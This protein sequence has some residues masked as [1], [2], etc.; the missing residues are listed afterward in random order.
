MTEQSD[1]RSEFLREFDRLG[2]VESE[3]SVNSE[4]TGDSMT[5]MAIENVAR[6]TDK[7]GARG[8]ASGAGRYSKL[9]R[10]LTAM[11]DKTW[12]LDTELD[13][14]FGEDALDA[15]L[16]G[17]L[18]EMEDGVLLDGVLVG[19]YLPGSGPSGQLAPV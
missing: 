2:K 17:R 15:A 10:L 6:L 9:G 4:Q 8:L 3:K 11:L 19:V 18:V 1:W 13:S 7:G 16:K 12:V 5:K 14:R